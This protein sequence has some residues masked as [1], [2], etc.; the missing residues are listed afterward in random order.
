MSF[1]IGQTT[2]TYSTTTTGTTATDVSCTLGGTSY[3]YNG[4]DMIKLEVGTQGSNYGK[5]RIVK[6][7]GTFSKSGTAYIKQDDICGTI[8]GEVTY[9][10]GA[11]TSSYMTVDYTH[12]SSYV[13]YYGVIIGNDALNTRYRTLPIKV[14][15]T[16]ITVSAPTN[17]S[18]T[19]GQIFDYSTTTI[20]FNWSK[21]NSTGKANYQINLRDLTTNVLKL[22][23]FD[24]GDANTINWNGAESGHEYQWVVRAVS[25]SN[26]SVTAQSASSTFILD[27]LPDIR[28]TSS[29]SFGSTTLYTGQS[30]TYTTTIKNYSTSSWSGPLFLK[31]GSSNIVTI[32]S[33]TIPANGS[34]S[35]SG[36][37]MPN[38]TGNYSL[39]LYYQTDGLGAGSVVTPNGYSNPISVNVLA[40]LGQPAPLSPSNSLIYPTAP[41]SITYQ[42]TKNN[43]SGVTYRLKIRDIT[44][45]ATNGPLVFDQNVGDVSSYTPTRIYTAGNTYRWVVIAERG[46]ETN[47][48]PAFTFSIAN[49]PANIMLASSTAFSSTSMIVGQSYTYTVNVKNTGGTSWNGPFYLKDALQNNVIII[50]STTI[51]AGATTSLSGSWTPTTVGSY[52]LTLYYQTG[53]LGAGTVVNANGYTNPISVTVT[54]PAPDN[55]LMSSMNFGS[56]SLFTGQ[57]YNFTTSV[58]NFSTKSW[59]GPLFLKDAL[60]NNVIIIPSTTIAAGATV[61]LSGS[62]TPTTV[63]TYSLTLYYQT[64]GLGAGTAVTTNGYS[65]P[66][67]VTVTDPA[68]DNRLMSS[69]SFGNTSLFTGQAYTFTTT[70]KNFSTKSWAGPLFLK[71]AA[72]NNVITISSTPIAAGATAT[73]TGYWTPT[74]VGTYS[75]TLYYQTGGLGAGTPV[76]ANGYSN[77]ISV[78]VNDPTPD[79]RLMS[80]MSFGS[81]SLFTGQA[82]T[83]TTTVKNFSTK[84]WAGPLFLKDAAGNNVITISSIPIAA[85]ATATLTGSW[86]PTTGGTYS[87]TLYFQTG[88]LGAGTPVTANGYSNPIS[89]TV[90][91]INSGTCDLSGLA[92]TNAYYDA[93]LDLC[94]RG[95]LSGSSADGAVDVTGNLKRSHLSKIAFLGLYTLNGRKVP[96]TLPSD[97]Y[98]SIYPDL[99]QTSPTNP[100]N[101][102][103]RAAKAL[104]YLEYGDGV[105]PFD[106]NRTNFNPTNFVARVDVLK[107]LF[108]AFNIKPELTNKTNPYPL[109]ANV[110][111]LLANNPLKFGY[112]RKA[113]DLGIITLPNGTTNTT[114]RPYD[115]CLRGEAFVILDRIIQKIEIDKTITDPNPTV[116]SYYQPLNLTIETLALGL[117]SQMGNFNNYTKSSFNIDGLVPLNFTHTYDSYVTDLPDE[118]YGLNELANGKLATYKPLGSGWSH[119]YHTFVTQIDGKLVIHWGGSKIAVYE[120]DGSVWKPKSIGVY[121]VVNLTN[122]I[123]TVKTK[124]QV[125]YSFKIH[126]T[127]V[128]SVFQL[129][130]IKDRNGNELLINYA[131]GVDGIM[132]ISNITDGQRKLTFAYKAGTN[133]ISSITDPLSRSIS[134]NYT[135]NS[136]LNEYLLTSYVDAKGQTTQYI[137]GTQTDFN[138]CKLI[139][140]IQM[141]KGNYIQNEYEANRLLQKTVAGVGAVP[142]TQTTMKVSLD[143]AAKTTQSDVKVTRGT[144][145]TSNYQ[146]KYNSSNMTTA[147]SGDQG[148]S[149]SVGYTNTTFK[150][151]PTS[152]SSNSSN[153]DNIQYDPAGNPLLVRK[154]SI[155]GSQT[156]TESMTYNSFNDILTYTDARGNVTNFDYDTNGNLIKVR[157]P[158]GSTTSY[159]VNTQGLPIETISPMGVKTT[160]AYNQYGNLNV[161][162]VPD[163]NL[164]STTVYDNASRVT[165]VTDF[166]NLQTT[167]QYDN[168]D[169]AL[170]EKNAMN[171]TT[172]SAYDA[173]DNLQ[174]I[175]NA[176]GGVTT[177]AYDAATD[178]LTSISF[179]GATK[180]FAYNSD[181]SLKTYTK[182]DGT[183]LTSTYDVLGRLVSDGVNSYSYDSNLRLSTVTRNSKTITLTYDG[184]SRISAVDYNDFA[185]NKVQYGYDAAGNIT[186]VTYPGGKTVNYTYDGL[187]RMKTV[188]DWNN[189]TINYSYRADNQPMTV[190]YPNG[191]NTSYTYDVGGRLTGKT[192]KRSDNTVIAGYTYQLDSL[193]NI[194][195][196]TR[197]EPYTD[198]LVTAGDVNYTYNTANRIEAAGTTAYT[199]D[200][201]GNNTKCGTSTYTWDATDQLATGDGF[202]YEYDGMG[203]RRANGTK[204]Y[205]IDIMGMGNVL[206]ESNSS[207]TPT[208]YYLHGMGLEARIKPDGTTEYYVSDFRGSTVAMVDA[209]SA[210]NITH[211]Y[212]YDEFG[213]VSQLQESD[214]NP[215]RYVGKYG[216]MYE[217]DHLYYMRARYYDPTVG[218][219]MSEDPVW[220]T[221]LY[222]YADNNPNTMI[223][224]DGRI[225]FTAAIVVGLAVSE[226]WSVGKQIYTDA[227]SGKYS[228]GNSYQN[229]NN[230]FTSVNV[231]VTKG[232]VGYLIGKIPVLGKSFKNIFKLAVDD[233]AYGNGKFSNK[234]SYAMEAVNGLIEY[235]IDKI[236]PTDK[237]SGK[238]SGKISD[239]IGFKMSSNGGKLIKELTKKTINSFTPEF[240]INTFNAQ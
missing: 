124:S 148:L 89:V 193:G 129:Y 142:T 36:T 208:Y 45:D 120:S 111:A 55:R 63:G 76:T 222:P 133:L 139:E 4:D 10:A 114:F 11:S 219:F 187:N 192:T 56:T 62:W 205:M 127:S 191:M 216:V 138:K 23:Y 116:N 233:L 130:S 94:G 238:I 95:I 13:N 73:L 14:T 231:G 180:Q 134:F 79:N 67:A 117:S 118:F 93:T 185:N 9:A 34:K 96:D 69:M 224:P 66:I 104:L 71:D 144:T 137:Y 88:G 146:Y 183:A 37:W 105:S 41:S 168:N 194:T 31:D 87:L 178:W 157:A 78:T 211:K 19:D 240:K 198:Q 98:P 65:N 72:G 75:L 39:T 151:L 197:T 26:S 181:G 131:A 156:I 70:V 212:Q 82:Y 53:G 169:N 44:T 107:V 40:P 49:A 6:A 113:A 119:S 147:I 47:D 188:V 155:T 58:K 86:T 179:G 115:N 126:N 149:T 209:S 103:Y 214:V 91:T 108:E 165:S 48:S 123:L 1:V 163:L 223:D 100:N 196:E 92:T 80:S 33:V 83:F 140:K 57:A 202:T 221:N 29:M 2:Y 85:G 235:G 30:Y 15:A 189:K 50:P 153:V 229:I 132:N 17:N 217:N 225:F 18:P 32:Q 203:K 59:S 90:T 174:T 226:V 12:T 206:A 172:S 177:M 145:A 182:P 28:L 38:T 8:V 35:I 160:F 210:A 232:G 21:N 121:D 97:D 152:L 150:D 7:S 84:S 74:T 5:F 204:R 227:N 77:P 215:F 207:G 22:N 43:S 46:T 190:V 81:T 20:N 234:Q 99:N 186:T 143:Y 218:R 195:K 237:I 122:G 199:F 52:S 106:R 230:F 54:D 236:D 64:G 176:K 136:S 60:Q 101:Y 164:K 213:G 51:A 125:V 110:T 171:Y 201:N 170:S 25:T 167:F 3:N 24:V 184:F 27:A 175:T 200:A 158:E 68:P 220:S 166:K 109:D 112:I 135:L 228:T 141:P 42:W 239:S 159:T 162:S 173:N 102:Y 16:T 61:L 128:F 161:V 154:K